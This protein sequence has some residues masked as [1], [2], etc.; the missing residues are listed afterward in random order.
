[1]VGY[2]NQNQLA[3]FACVCIAGFSYGSKEVR[4]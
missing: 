1:M 2:E 4:L 3:A